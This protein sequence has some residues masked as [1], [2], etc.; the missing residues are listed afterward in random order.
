MTN[1]KNKISLWSK[2]QSQFR[3]RLPYF[4]KGSKSY[5]EQRY[6][7]GGNSGSGS[8]G[9]FAEFKANKINTFVST[10]NVQTV[11]EFGCGD[12]HQLK[13]AKYPSYL[14]FDVSET[15]V[16]L[17]QK[18]F[19]LDTTKRFDL[20]K[21]YKGEMA[22]LTLSLDVI[23]HLIEDDVFSGYMTTLFNASNKYV[24][25]YSSDTD[26]NP[27]YSSAHVKNKHFTTWISASRPD[28]KLIEYHD[29]ILGSPSNFYVYQRSV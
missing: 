3:W 10:H 1:L 8:Y 19:A 28:W 27:W 2:F 6:L 12:G 15:A 21:N 29:G 7:H 17:C 23:F 5:W 14:G 9:K 22:D 18:E 20:M 24:V 25:I 11:I 26:K 13:L 16:S 4:F